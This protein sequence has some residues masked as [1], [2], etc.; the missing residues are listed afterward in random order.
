VI[1]SVQFP[2]QSDS[3]KGSDKNASMGL[4][5]IPQFVPLPHTLF[6]FF[7][8][9]IFYLLTHLLT[10]CCCCRKLWSSRAGSNTTASC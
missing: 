6:I 2:V 9:L 5:S 10:H 4:E 3:R 7:I 1:Q 8:S